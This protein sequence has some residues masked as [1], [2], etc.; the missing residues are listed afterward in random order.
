MEGFAATSS[1]RSATIRVNASRIRT[2][3]HFLLKNTVAFYGRYFHFENQ[4]IL[5]FRRSIP[6]L[7]R[8]FNQ[9]EDIPAFPAKRASGVRRIRAPSRVC[10]IALN[11]VHG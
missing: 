6:L 1:R 11:F 3:A 7:F 2:L 8:G 9:P 5:R 4:K 10:D